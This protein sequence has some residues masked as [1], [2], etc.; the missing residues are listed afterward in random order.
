MRDDSLLMVRR[1]AHQTLAGQGGAR[2]AG[3][4]AEWPRSKGSGR[5]MWGDDGGAEHQKRE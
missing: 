3:Q 5:S 2:K 1:K 4:A